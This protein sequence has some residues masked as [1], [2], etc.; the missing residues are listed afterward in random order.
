[1]KTVNNMET[2]KGAIADARNHERD[3][4]GAMTKDMKKKRGD[5]LKSAAAAASVGVAVGAGKGNGKGSKP[6]PP[7]VP[8]FVKETYLG[9]GYWKLERKIRVRVERY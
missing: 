4:I 9:F 2:Y 5:R 7:S 1:M 8:I 3:R 6:P